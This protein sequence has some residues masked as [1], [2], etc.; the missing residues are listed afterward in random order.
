LFEV[1]G[2]AIP[3][4][5]CDRDFGKRKENM[6]HAIHPEPGG[7]HAMLTEQ[8]YFPPAEWQ[9]LRDSDFTAG[10]HIVLLMAGIFVTGL[11]MYSIVAWW[12]GTW[13]PV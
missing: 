4:T 7:H 13:P 5:G 3:I 10:K 2:I 11:F 9:A 8:T 6:V 1:A 12:V